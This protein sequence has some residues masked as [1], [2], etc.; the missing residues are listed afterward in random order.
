MRYYLK[1]IV[2]ILFFQFILANISA[3]IYA[4]KFT[5]YYEGPPP[6]TH[7][8]N[9][10]EKT[11]KLFV[12]PKFYKNSTES[13]PVFEYDSIKLK[14]SNDLIIDAWYSEADS[15]K[16]CIILLHG[17]TMN[18]SS[19]LHE[20]YLFKKWGYSVM[21]IDFR[22]HGK[23]NGNNTSFGADET[24]EAAKAFEFA[25]QKGNKKIIFYGVSLGAIVALKGTADQKIQ[26]SGI[27]A[28]A[29]FGNL[30]NYMKSRSRE[31]GFPGEPFGGLV[32]FWIGL[33]KGYNGF[34]HDVSEYAE[35]VNCPVLL[36][37]GERDRYVSKEEITKVFNNMASANK[38][39]VL[40]P[41]ADHESYLRVDPIKW[42]SEMISFLDSLK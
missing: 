7:P 39:L 35:K 1:W 2:W 41:D 32:T 36:E 33:K 24:E 10:L 11:W 15:S 4:H 16:G 31:L 13:L 19:L 27:I 29:P 5:H 26:P 18:K 9:V 34:N 14:L 17:L 23:S 25:Q 28:E 38:K 30:H 37:C 20:A 22:G 8:K 12:G 21:L 42:E 40:Y 6:E 3:S